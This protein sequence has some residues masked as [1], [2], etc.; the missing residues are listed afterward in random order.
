MCCVSECDIPEAAEPST[1]PKRPPKKPA[2]FADT[3]QPR[4]LRPPFPSLFHIRVRTDLFK[5]LLGLKAPTVDGK[6]AVDQE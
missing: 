1:K 4:R 6:D 3:T 5:R 2:L